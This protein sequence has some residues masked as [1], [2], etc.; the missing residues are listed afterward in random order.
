MVYA[1]DTSIGRLRE[2][3]PEFPTTVGYI[4]NSR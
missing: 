3:N 2:E 1:L 4:T